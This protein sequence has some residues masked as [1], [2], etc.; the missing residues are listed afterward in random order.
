LQSSQ[1][2]ENGKNHIN[3]W[4]TAFY[5]PNLASA[6]NLKSSTAN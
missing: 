4:K 2:E 3:H 6:E 5:G 1:L